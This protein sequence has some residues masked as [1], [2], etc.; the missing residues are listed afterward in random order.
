MAGEEISRAYTFGNDPKR[1]VRTANGD[2][3]FYSQF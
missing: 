2:L 3:P 1:H